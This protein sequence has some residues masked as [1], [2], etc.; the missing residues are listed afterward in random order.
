MNRL[1]TEKRAQILGML[2]EGMS[3][4][5]VSRLTGVSINT[6]TKLLLDAGEACAVAHDEMVRDVHA[7]RIQ[8]DEM[9]GFVYAKQK[10]VPKAKAAP[11]G[12]GDAW[13]WTALDADSKM[14]VSWAIGPRE[15]STALY[16]M[17]DLRSRLA[18]R[19][20]LTS[21]GLNAYVAA[22]EAVFGPEIDFAQLV[23]LYGK[24]GGE[25][26]RRYSPAECIGTRRRVRMGNPDPAKIS[27]SYVERS[28]LSMRMGNR[29]LT[30][31]TNAFSKRLLHHAAMLSLYFLHYNFCRV[32]KSLRVTPAME[33][34]LDTTVRSLEWIV[35]LIDA[36]APKPNRPKTYRTKKNRQISD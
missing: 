10:N 3:M 12:A 23:K 31:L 17:D 24:G 4:R 30:R 35:G 11:E 19:V 25:S 28:N 26:D 33:A 21:D 32:H 18:D 36:R 2:V 13:A 14:I 16:V 7:A 20:Q 22:V 34:G 1:A 6:V 9:W 29:R 5:A 8:V 15:T 27:T